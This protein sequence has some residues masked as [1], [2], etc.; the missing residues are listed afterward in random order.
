MSER[1]STVGVCVCVYVC[2]LCVHVCMSVCVFG[3]VRVCMC[4]ITVDLGTDIR[5]L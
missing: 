1:H 2:Y 5:A 3:R 4:V